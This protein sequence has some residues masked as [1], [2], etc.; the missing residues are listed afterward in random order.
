[1]EN[2]HVGKS[3]IVNDDNFIFCRRTY[4]VKQLEQIIYCA[5]K[6]GNYTSMEL[7]IYI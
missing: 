6:E 1:M 3:V 5:K 4:T 7:D 2:V